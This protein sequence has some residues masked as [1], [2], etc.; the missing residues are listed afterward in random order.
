MRGRVRTEADAWY[1]DGMGV[2]L[3]RSAVTIDA[4]RGDGSASP[5]TVV[6]VRGPLIDVPEL[7]TL[8]ARG[9]RTPRA[10][11]RRFFRTASRCLTPTSVSGWTA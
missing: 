9:P 4:H 8:R 1:L 10:S 6:A 11:T 7:A 2:K 3:G 5:V